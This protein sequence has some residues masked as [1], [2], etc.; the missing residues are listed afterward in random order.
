MNL[1]RILSGTPAVRGELVAAGIF[2][3]VWFAMDIIQFSD[4]AM[5]KLNPA[6]VACIKMKE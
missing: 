1:H 6:P 5:L 3:A 2:V 4:W